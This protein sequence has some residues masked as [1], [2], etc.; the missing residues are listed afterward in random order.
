[1]NE[2]IFSYFSIRELQFT[3][4]LSRIEQ[5]LQMSEKFCDAAQL[6]VDL[7]VLDPRRTVAHHTAI[8]CSGASTGPNQ[9]IHSFDC[10]YR[11]G[12]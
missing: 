9:H 12:N 2:T 8:S 1:M 11:V 3:W 5:R 10:F 7:D 6:P 4:L